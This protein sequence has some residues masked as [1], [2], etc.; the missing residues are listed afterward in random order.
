[1][2]LEVA[3]SKRILKIGKDEMAKVHDAMSFDN[4]Q[5][6]YMK[7]IHN[8][9]LKMLS[10]GVAMNS[11]RDNGL[12]QIALSLDETQDGD[13]DLFSWTRHLLTMTCVTAVWG[14]ENRFS[15]DPEIEGA[16]WYDDCSNRNPLTIRI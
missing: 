15:K 2:P 1:M 3:V 16:F 5:S 12:K 9:H 13:V 7:Q 11:M 14:E 10:P 4:G 8:T 6:G